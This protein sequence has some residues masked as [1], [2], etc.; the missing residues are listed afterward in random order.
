[1]APPPNNAGDEFPDFENMS[2]EE[3]M[4]WLESLA[5]R[6]GANEEEFTTAADL[7]IPI[8][9]DAVIDEPGYVPYSESTRASSRETDRHEPEAEEEMAAVSSESIETEPAAAVSEEAG[10]PMMWLDSLAAHPGGGLDD[11]ALI[12]DED[13]SDLLEDLGA[14]SEM[15]LETY[16]D[17]TPIQEEE[18]VFEPEEIEPE[19]AA[20]VDLGAEASEDDLSALIGSDPMLWLETL[21]KR[22]GASQ[23]QLLTSADMEVG[24]VPEDVVIDEPGYVPFDVLEGRPRTQPSVPDEEPVAE[25]SMDIGTDV[26]SQEWPVEAVTSDEPEVL[27]GADP[28]AWLETLAEQQGDK[29]EELPVEE[30]LD[31]LEMPEDMAI[32]ETGG[33]EFAPVEIVAPEPEAADASLSWLEDLASEADTDV[34]ELLAFDD[35]VFGEREAEEPAAEVERVEDDLLAGMTD[36]EVALA[37]A[38]GQLT[39]EQEVEWLKRKAAALAEVRQGEEDVPSEPELEPALPGDLPDWLQEMKAEAQ[40][41]SE[42]DEGFLTGEQVLSTEGV[43]LDAWLAEVES[44]IEYEHTD[45]LTLDADVETLWAD[46]GEETEMPGLEPAVESD[47][48]AFVEAGMV[49]EEPDQLAEALDVEFD[50]KMIDDDSEPEWYTDAVAK[51]LDE[52]TAEALTPEAPVGDEEAFEVLAEES[53]LVEAA[54]V[55][56]PDWL[57]ETVEEAAP[58]TDEAMPS[59]LTESVETP[60]IEDAEL[61]PDWLTEVADT[62]EAEALEWLPQEMALPEEE[63]IETV[64]PIEPPIEVAEPP[65][66]KPVEEKVE[67]PEP[68]PQPSIPAGELFSQYRMRLEQNPDDYPTRLALARALRGSQEL[69]SSLDHYEALIDSSQLLQDVLDDLDGLTKEKTDLPRLRRLLGDVYMRQ[70]KLQEALDAYRTALDQL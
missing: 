2:P 33:D 1:M 13:T 24:E 4:A 40:P 7:D 55:D 69:P 70:G 3:Q 12:S 16:T 10:D 41:E 38:Q 6:Q 30:D 25:L 62:S 19:L 11:L 27:E 50:R 44:E 35:G 22:Q 52:T 32:Q 8:P 47:L 21:A 54:P 18:E 51:I 57:K 17:S 58:I 34:S 28:M 59:W 63:S 42:V 67:V 49:P 64:L 36:E 66:Q 56:M 9:Q 61:V 65:E 48:E 53:D 29:P 37:Q 14:L 5:K 39:R 23:E 31:M 43:E 60:V 68:V 15:P 20:S 46:I 26:E 45:E